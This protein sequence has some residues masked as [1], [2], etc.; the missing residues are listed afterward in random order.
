[1]LDARGAGIRHIFKLVSAMQLVCHLK[2]LTVQFFNQFKEE[3]TFCSFLYYL[4]RIGVPFHIIVNP[5]TEQLI[6]SNPFNCIVLNV[7]KWNSCFVSS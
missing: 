1:M 4:L 3:K 7:R 2:S 6:R 5:W